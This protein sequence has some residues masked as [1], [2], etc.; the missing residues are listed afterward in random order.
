[1][2]LFFEEEFKSIVHFK[3]K[4]QNGSHRAQL[5]ELNLLKHYLLK[6]ATDSIVIWM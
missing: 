1:M 5:G 6:E 3:P 4:N 2:Y